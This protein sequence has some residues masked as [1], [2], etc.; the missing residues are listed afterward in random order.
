MYRSG[1]NFEFGEKPVPKWSCTELALT[2]HFM[3]RT[4]VGF[5]GRQIE[6]RNFWF[7]EDQDGGS[8]WRYMYLWNGSPEQSKLVIVRL[9]QSA[10]WNSLWM[11][12]RSLGDDA[13]Q[14]K[15]THCLLSC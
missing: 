2:L 10:H 8:K 4:S 12:Y 15:S 7:K 1:P 9:W 14:Y 3:F 13:V 6:R 11:C 5:S